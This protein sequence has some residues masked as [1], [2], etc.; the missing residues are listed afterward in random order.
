MITASIA[1][2]SVAKARGIFKREE[3]E[4]GPLLGKFFGDSCLPGSRSPFHEKTG[5][6]P[7]SLC[8]L[9]QT[10]ALQLPIVPLKDPVDTEYDDDDEATPEGSDTT[11]SVPFIPNRSIDCDASP[12]N[13][14][15]GTR[16]SLSCLNEIGDIAVLEHQNLAQHAEAL[17]LDENNFRILCRNGSLAAETGFN[18]D[19][20]C[21]LTTIVDGEVVVN[22]NMDKA[23]TVVNVL[24]SLDKYLQHDPDFKMYNIFANET[25]LLFE[26]SAVGLVS[27]NSKVLGES[28]QNYIQLF[29]DVEN[30]MSETDAANSIVVNF[31]LT[32]SLVIITIFIKN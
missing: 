21:F 24:M 11:T 15:Y 13:R 18:V 23:S 4:F 20:G 1:F 8:T 12:A 32:I 19:V 17:N 30:C 28:V 29:D 3:C 27:P 16:G 10:K 22:R 14:Y 6:N 5:N 9:C 25:N 26:D 7:D 31:L 2:I